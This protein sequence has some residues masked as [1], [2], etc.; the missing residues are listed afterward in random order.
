MTTNKTFCFIFPGRIWSLQQNIF[1]ITKHN[2]DKLRQYF[3]ICVQIYFYSIPPSPLKFPHNE[4]YMV[5][6][7]APA[8]LWMLISWK[9]AR[10]V[11]PQNPLLCLTGNILVHSGELHFPYFLFRGRTMPGRLVIRQAEARA[12]ITTVDI[13]H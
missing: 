8:T 6:P 3:L 13:Q 12:L 11:S 10:I 1:L 9:K 4:A 2:F 5:L 7:C